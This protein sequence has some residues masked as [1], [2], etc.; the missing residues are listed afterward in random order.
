MRRVAFIFL[1]LFVCASGCRRASQRATEVPAPASLPTPQIDPWKQAALKVEEDRGEPVGRQAK[2]D[3]PEELKQYKE[4]R[5]F[6]SIQVAEWREQ[7]IDTPHDFAALVELIKRGELTEVPA[8]GDDYILYGVGLTATDEPMTHYDKA[9]GKS[10]TLYATDQDFE[11]EYAQLKDTLSQRGDEIKALA[12]EL[13]ALPKK[14]RDQRKTLNDEITEK[15][16]DAE[17]TKNRLDL[18][19]SFY[20]NADRRRLLADEYETLASFA[21]DF[22]GKSYDLQ[23]PAARREFKARLLS[24]VRP[25]AL[26]VIKEIAHT[27]NEKFSRHLP[28]TSLVRTDEYQRQLNTVNPNATLIETAPHTTGLAFDIYYHFMTKAEQEFVMTDIARLEDAGRVEALRELRDH[29]HV[30]AFAEGHPPDAKLVEQQIKQGEGRNGGG[31]GDNGND[32][33]KGKKREERAAKSS[34]GKTKAAR[35]GKPGRATKANRAAKVKQPTR[36]KR[37][38]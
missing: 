15:K 32:N 25:P 16:R 5:R 3:V 30:F 37:R 28:V 21:H 35:G 8:L 22:G 13:A 6:L 11:Q 33:S 23:D 29:F 1:A 36:A 24:F 20:R 26:A 38:K 31:G 9:S 7:K 34:P 14:E 12:K 10:V 27:Y 4:R 18:L 17:A 2:V 19:D